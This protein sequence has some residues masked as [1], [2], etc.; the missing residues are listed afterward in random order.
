MVSKKNLC[1]ILALALVFGMALAG[2]DNSGG[3]GDGGGGGGDGP[4][5]INGYYGIT[6]DGKTIEIII[7]SSN[8]TAQNARVL[9]NGTYRTMINGIKMSEGTCQN[10]NGMPKFTSIDGVSTVALQIS[11]GV[12]SITVK[13][14]DNKTYQGSAVESRDWFYCVAGGT[15]F[16]ESE[17]NEKFKN[18]T[19]LEI[20]TYIWAHEG[21]DFSTNSDEL[22]EI[23]WDDMV[24]LGKTMPVPPSDSVLQEVAS[25][26]KGNVCGIYFLKDAW[27]WDKN[28]PKMNL[29][30]FVSRLPFEYYGLNKN[31]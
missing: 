9:L 30:S 26:M 28:N 23:T 31:W 4:E 5:I 7:T 29:I 27:L 18:K 21:T 14:T 17:F 13:G 20:F 19:M 1:G 25:N 16:T 12:L 8:K 22:A 11:G 24:K 3:G 10:D 6:S 2:C 15:V